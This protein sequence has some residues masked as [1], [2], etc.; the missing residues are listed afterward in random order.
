LR[1]RGLEVS[2]TIEA[3]ITACRDPEQLKQWLLAAARVDRAG[4]LFEP[5]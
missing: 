3:E 5:R 1:A 2:G 4:A